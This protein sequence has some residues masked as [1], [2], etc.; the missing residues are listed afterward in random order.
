[1]AKYKKDIIK[2]VTS[3]FSQKNWEY[4]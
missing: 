2:K 4:K 1:L 3:C